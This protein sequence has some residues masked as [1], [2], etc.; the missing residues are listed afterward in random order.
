MLARLN[1]A[2]IFRPNRAF[3]LKRS[4]RF[5]SDCSAETA[6]GTSNANVNKVGDMVEERLFMFAS[7]IKAQQ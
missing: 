3:K 6:A 5:V 4:S 1:L 2:E 7:R